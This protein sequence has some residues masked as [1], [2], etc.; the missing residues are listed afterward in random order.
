MSNFISCLALNRTQI[1]NR[2]QT[3]NYI[4]G[5]DPKFVTDCGAGYPPECKQGVLTE[6]IDV[7]ILVHL[8]FR[9]F[10]KHLGSDSDSVNPGRHGQ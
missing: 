1:N 8:V 6:A 5:I 10:A 9:L 2:D 7:Y 3:V 4:D